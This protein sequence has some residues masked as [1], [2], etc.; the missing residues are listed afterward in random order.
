MKNNLLLIIYSL[1]CEKYKK[2]IEKKNIFEL[3]RII[4][5][6]I[7]IKIKSCSKLHF[8]TDMKN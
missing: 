2:K 7:K 4:K 3:R 8:G 1:L 5:K 6:I